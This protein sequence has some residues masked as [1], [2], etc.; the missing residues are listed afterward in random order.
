MN[1]LTSTAKKLDTFFKIISVLL[2]IAAIGCLVGAAIIAIGFLLH[3]S[4]EQ[5]GT[6]FDVLTVG[7]LALRL[8]AGY[9]PDSGL[10]LIQ[11]TVTLLLTFA[12]IV[13]GH[14]GVKQI[15]TMLQ[16]MVQGEPF[17]SAVSTGLKKLTA[18]TFILGIVTNC[19][20]LFDHLML[21]YCHGLAELLLSEK[22]THVSVNYT[23][24]L[25]FLAVCAVLLL[26]SYIFHYGEQL[27]QL[28][29]ETL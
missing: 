8:A 10:T 16:P 21:F 3:L 20:R 9:A 26:L 5:I 22:I 29:D 19:I 1:E 25:G 13:I 2:K 7:P 4:P 6:D 15:R 27:Q 11:T 14:L 23:F 24:R 17:H 12:C 18:L 28:S